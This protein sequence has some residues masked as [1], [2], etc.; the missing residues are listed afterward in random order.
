MGYLMHTLMGC[1]VDFLIYVSID[2]VV[3]FPIGLPHRLV[4]SYELPA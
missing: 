3:E 2:S 1:F 4:G